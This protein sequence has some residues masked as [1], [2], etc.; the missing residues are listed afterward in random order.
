[1]KKLFFWFFLIF[2][3]NCA[4]KTN[5]VS[6]NNTKKDAQFLHIL[7]LAPSITETISLL[8]ASENLVGITEY[9]KYPQDLLKDK[10]RIGGFTNFNFELISALKP[11]SAFLLPIHQK[12]LENF[13]RLKI[14]CILIKQDTI[15][16]IKK[17]IFT[18]GE[19]LDK[20]DTALKLIKEIE[21]SINNVKLQISKLQ[22]KKVL[23]IV[24]RDQTKL[25]AIFAAGAK[26][27]YN[28]IINRLGLINALAENNIEYPMISIESIMAINPDIIIEIYSPDAGM[29]ARRTILELKNDWKNL[30]TV[31]AVKNNNI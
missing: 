16:D 2:F 18:I 8:G 20:T 23:M 10:H 12:E 11:D 28:D 27:F 1:M 13:K 7:S 5:T 17:S 14:D 9:C 26:T 3:A 25:S 4:N 31:N 21:D 22:N 30:K 19:Y 6:S 15:D 29:T 24:S